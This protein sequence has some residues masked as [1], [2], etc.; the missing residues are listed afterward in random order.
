MN[1]CLVFMIILAVVFFALYGQAQNLLTNEGFE[2]WTGGTPDGWDVE[3]SITLTQESSTVH[4]GVYSLGLEA[5]SNDNRGV[6][7][8]IPVTAGN[9]Y[10][11]QVYFYASGSN[12]IGIYVNWLDSGGGTI[13]GEGTYYNVGSGAWEL[14][15]TDEITAP[16]GAVNARCRIRCYANTAFGGNA[17]DAAFFDT[18]GP[19]PTQGP[20]NT[21]GPTYTPT[22]TP[23]GPTPTPEPYTSIYDIQFSASGPSPYEGQV[24]TTYGVVYAFE[25]GTPY[26][27]MQ[28]GQGAWNGFLVYAPADAM[29]YGDEILIT[30]TVTEYYDMTEFGAGATVEL[31][32]AGNTPPDPEILQT[33][34]VSAEQW[35]SVFVRVENVEITDDDLGYSEWEIDD[36][37][38]PCRVNDLFNLTFIPIQGTILDYVQGPL[39]FSYGDFKIEPRSD[40]DIGQGEPT[41]T[42]TGPT[43]TPTPFDPIPIYD[44]QYSTTGPSSY[45]GQEVA[46]QGIVSA[47]HAD[48]YYVADAWTPWS[49]IYVYR[50]LLIGPE[51]GDEVRVIGTVDEYYDLTEIVDVEYA[52]IISHNNPVQTII[53]TADDYEDES[54]ESVLVEFTGTLAVQS[55]DGF[56]QWTIDD[57]IGQV[58]IDDLMDYNY[59]P[60]VADEL[61]TIIG[62]VTYDYSEWKIE[63]RCTMD[64]AG[65][66]VH[67]YCLLGDVVTMND[68]RD[69]LLDHYVEIRGD[70]IIG[71]S[72]TAPGGVQVIDTDGL[73]FPG[74]I[75]SHNHPTYNILTEIPFPCTFS[76]RS[77]WQAHTMYG[78]FYDQYNAIRYKSGGDRYTEL[79]KIA[80][81]RELIVGCTMIQG[82]N[83]TGHDHDYYAHQGMI[84]DNVERFPG[85]NFASVF[86]MEYGSDWVNNK[87][88]QFYWRRFIIHLSEGTNSNA[89]NEFATWKAWGMLDYRTAIIHGVPLGTEQWNDMADAN[90]H[91]IWSP[92]SNWVL[93]HG[94]ADVPSAIAAGI[95]VALAPDWTESGKDNILE[96]MKFANE[97]NQDHFG[98]ILTAQD[99]AEM[100]TC[101]AARA[102]A[103]DH[104]AGTIEI[105]YRANI[106]IIPGD[107]AQPYDALLNSTAGDVRLTV[108]GGRPLYGDADLMDYFPWMTGQ[109]DITICSVAKRIDITVEAHGIPDSDMTLS[110]VENE[111]YNAY[112]NAPYLCDYVSYDPCFGGTP[113]PTPTQG[114]PTATPTNTPT[115]ST[116]SP[117]PT[118]TPTPACDTLGVTLDMPAH[119]F[120]PDDNCYLKVHI[121]NPDT[122]LGETPLFV[123][124]DVYG[125]LL[126]APDFNEFGY[127]R[128]NLLSG[129]QTKTVLPDFAWPAGAGSASGL[130]WYAGMTNPEISSLL[131]DMDTW[132]FAWH[133]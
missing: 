47:A 63:P 20:T 32:S 62:I 25:T 34:E 57:G 118:D 30:G 133:E 21:Q 59:F 11:F 7:Q 18:S 22:S 17:D 64:I 124:L 76:E 53:V 38:G 72:D 68:S 102:V 45:D 46:F 9:T 58:S 33:G 26:I 19:T 44:I 95:N 114:P 83:C 101:N 84:I 103:L 23:T 113:T 14:V 86:P 29:V 87:R 128:I 28:D 37:S 88:D 96:E 16:A 85:R 70:T 119:D 125:D 52:E 49:A 130:Y 80:E 61:T 132:E 75:D 111:L 109:E 42:P 54:M 13:S 107:A 78:D 41:A 51:I 12:S 82:R 56:G 27:W 15:T 65:P 55:L 35:E 79:W 10:E 115:G 123:I 81:A 50:D 110:Y 48:G 6:F 98:G 92:F 120:G 43:P 129:L 108:V 100:V 3:S 93:Y 122:S 112:Q 105:N 104:M 8:I 24:V 121:C 94:V 89:L 36:G 117:T 5:T 39:D 97:I 67:H 74:L 69:V 73:I 4:T 106:M 116:P 99:L 60:Q 131:G 127:Y 90:A 66:A 40:A 1:T 91:L 77:E 71:L 31:L 2:D 126:F